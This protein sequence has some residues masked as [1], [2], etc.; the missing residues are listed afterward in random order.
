MIKQTQI[1]AYACAWSLCLELIASSQNLNLPFCFISYYQ[2]LMQSA[3]LLFIINVKFPIH[4]D[5]F[6]LGITIVFVT[7][8]RF[9]AVHYILSQSTDICH[10]LQFSSYC[11]LTHSQITVLGCHLEYNRAF[12][13]LFN[14]KIL[15]LFFTN[16]TKISYFIFISVKS[17]NGN[18]RFS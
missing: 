3:S 18:I 11:K 15:I 10:K 7:K 8:Y 2:V 16:V 12:L 13:Y 17:Q 14:I 4:C 9:F 6:L 1:H 5:S